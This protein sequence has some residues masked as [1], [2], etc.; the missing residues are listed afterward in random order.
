VTESSRGTRRTTA[1]SKSGDDT[2]QPTRARRARP[3]TTPKKTTT[4]KRGPGLVEAVSVF[5]GLGRATRSL[6]IVVRLHAYP[7]GHN[8]GSEWMLHSML[9]AL[10]ARGHKVQVWLSRYSSARHTYIVDGIEVIPFAARM[11]W[12]AAVR[13]ADVVV[14]HLENVPPTAGLAQAVAKPFVA[15]CHNTAPVIFKNVGRSGAALV[16]YNSDHMVATAREYFTQHPEAT[17]PAKT[18]VV[19]PPVFGGDYATTPGGKVTLV[20][21]NRDKGGDVFWH[22]AERLPDVQFLGVKGAYGKQ[23][24]RRGGLENVEVIDHLPGDRMR[25]EVYAKTRILLMPSAHESWG[26]VA[27][28]AM[29][30]GIPVVAAPTPGLVE[31]LADAGIFVERGDLDGWVATVEALTDPAQWAQASQAASAR[32]KE[33]DPSGDLAAWCEAIEALA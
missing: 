7:P 6:R 25:D 1:A 19:R 23:V 16:V 4:A 31:C 26:R 10:A 32:A 27:V 14:A 20:N 28:E 12:G 22:L 8:A 29:A 9:R 3:K 11:N 24:E 18:L 2:K 21:L 15:V 17:E 33:L 13:D 5:E 30:S